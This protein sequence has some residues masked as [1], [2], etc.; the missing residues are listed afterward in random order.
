MATKTPV[1]GLTVTENQFTLVG[2]V[3]WVH[4]IPSVDEAPMVDPLTTA[5]YRFWPAVPPVE[6]N[7]T[8]TFADGWTRG[9]VLTVPVVPPT[10]PFTK[11]RRVPA[12]VLVL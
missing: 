10:P 4:V 9:C 5:T 11:T 2:K 8:I 7:P 6:S 1:L 12:V 3:R